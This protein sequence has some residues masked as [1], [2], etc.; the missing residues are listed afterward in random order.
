[1]IL[2]SWCGRRRDIEE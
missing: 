1:L 2:G